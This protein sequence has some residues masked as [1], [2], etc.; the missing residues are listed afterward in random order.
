MTRFLV[1]FLIASSVGVVLLWI[2]SKT[3]DQRKLRR[4]KKR[5]QARL[6]ELRLYGDEPRIVL[7]AQ[8]QL[9]KENL[10]YFAIMLGPA[11]VV[12]PVMITLLIIL[13]GFFGMRPIAPGEDVTLTLQMATPVTAKTPAPELEAPEGI[14]VETPAVRD[15]DDNQ[16][17]WRIR[18]ERP[19]SGDLRIVTPQGVLT[20]KILAGSGIHFLTSRRVDS[21]FSWLLHPG[22]ALLGG[23]EVKWIE[24]AYPSAEIS[25]LGWKAHWLVWFLIISMGVAFVLKGRFHVSF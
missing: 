12:M 10:R 2:F 21:V 4:T 13:E 3:S 19:V 20:K 11:R 18:A 22:E 15:I 1:L 23:G 8:K 5:L 14:V 16:V 6:L 7:R 24:V 17:S 25:F 9:L